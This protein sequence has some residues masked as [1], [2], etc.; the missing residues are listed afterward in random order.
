MALGLYRFLTALA[1]PLAGFV[2]QKRLKAGK[3]D[4]KRWRERLGFTEKTRPAGTLLWLHGASVGESLSLL[5]LAEKARAAKLQVLM[6][7][8]TVAAAEILAQRKPDGALHQ[9]IPIDTPQAVERFVK[10]WQPDVGV[11]A[12]SEWWPNLLRA[13]HGHGTRLMLASARISDD[14]AQGWL[15]QPKAAGQLLRLFSTIL[16]QDQASFDRLAALGRTPD[17]LANLK[18]TGAT[19]PADPQRLDEMRHQIGHRPVLLAAS[20][21]P[22]ED[23]IVLS[24]FARVQSRHPLALLIIAPRHLSRAGEITAMARSMD[25]I[26]AQR[27]AHEPITAQTSVYLADTLGEMGLWYRLALGALVGGSLVSDVGGHNP[28]EPAR[29]NC[30]VISGPHTANFEI[31]SAL[32]AQNAARLVADTP[33]LTTAFIDALAGKLNAQTTTAYG[34]AAGTDAA[35]D[36][37][38]AAITRLLGV[39]G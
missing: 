34:I 29:L 12:E 39:K 25:F 7:S 22:G 15:R 36:A 8:G 27:S 2:L 37:T 26:T 23:E 17:G 3:E 19:L 28:L 21:H 38:W 9:Y 33:A 30:P 14:T 1:H 24:A 16:A 6:T 31:Y 20:T 32:Y 5:P 10:H 4:P 13:A 18:L 35:R 11:F